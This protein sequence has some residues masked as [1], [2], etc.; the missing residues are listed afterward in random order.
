MP[1]ADRSTRP[2]IEVDGRELDAA[3]MP[4]VERT[5]VDDHLHLPDTFELTIRDHARDVLER[6]SIRIGSRV[7]ISAPALGSSTAQALITGEVTSVEAAYTSS[8]SKVIVRGYDH[9][10]RLARGR[11]TE[12]YRNVKCSDVARTV[13]SRAGLEAGTIDDSGEVLEYVAQANQTDLEFL[14]GLARPIGFEVA[15]LDGKLDFRRPAQA[16]EAPGSGDYASTDP[17]QLVF[18]QDLLEFRP[19]VTSAGQVGEV[20][21][22]GW[23]VA[24]KA[25]LVGT[26]PGGTTTVQLPDTPADLASRFGNPTHV[27]V[28]RAFGTQRAVDDAA[29]ATADSIGSAIAEATAKARGNPVLRAGKPVSVSLVAAPFAGRYTLTHTRHVFDDEAGYVT[30]LVVSGR[31]ERSLLGLASAAAAG[32]SAAQFAGVVIGIVT[33]AADPETLGRV[34]LRFPWLADEFETDWA[35]VV[36]LGAGPDRGAVFVPEVNDEVL[37]A[38]EHGEFRSPFVIGGLWN[39][40]DKPPEHDTS[41][42]LQERSIVSRLGNKVI[43]IDKDGSAGIRLVTAGGQCEI[44]LDDGS[45]EVVIKSGGGKVTIE[46][47]SDVTFKSSGNFTIQSQGNIDIKASGNANIQASAMATVKGSQVQLG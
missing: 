7:K 20:Q 22:R 39:G 38:F 36:M 30:E 3:V 19:R 27:V 10:H 17:T 25:A 29:R 32:A 40:Q 15:V 46:A 31:Q 12:T 33:D 47:Q 45:N 34:K 21:V 2:T 23:S 37:V 8:G 11:R 14:R 35:R 43:L 16:S 4:D 24:D 5:V 28:D 9:A 41:G 44:L 1:D 6:T 26:A 13:A 42:G 18:G